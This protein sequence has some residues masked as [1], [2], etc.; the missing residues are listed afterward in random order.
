LR[1]LA[2]DKLARD[3]VEAPIKHRAQVEVIR[4]HFRKNFYAWAETGGVT[5]LSRRV[6]NPGAPAM[7]EENVIGLIY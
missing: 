1:K 2:D 3:C 4:Q 7:F 5:L 6:R